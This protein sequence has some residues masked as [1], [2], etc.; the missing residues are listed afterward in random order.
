[1]NKRNGYLWA[2]IV[3]FSFIYGFWSLTKHNRFQTDAVDL[4]IFDQP[5][6]HYSRFETP[7]STVKYNQYPGE[8]ILGDHFHPTIALLSPLYWVWDDVRIILIAQAVLVALSVWPIYQVA[9]KLFNS[10]FF[11]LCLSFSYLTFIGL[12]TALDYDFHEITIALLPF[13]F[14]IYFLLRGKNLLY[15]LS[16]ALAAF[17]K[18][19]MTLFVAMLGLFSIF[20]FKK[21]KLGLVTFV[22][23]MSLYFIVTQVFIPFFKHDRFAYEELD[24]RLGKTTLDLIQT[25]FTNPV[26]VISTIF[27][28]VLKAKTILNLLASFAFLPLL[29]PTA[30]LMT[31]PNLAS[32]FLTRLSQ[33]WLIRFQYNAVLSPILA[34]AVVFGL[35]RLKKISFI[36]KRFGQILPVF[37]VLLVVAPLLQTVRTNSPLLRIFN[38]ASYKYEERFLVNYQLLSRIPKDGGVSV[39]AQSSFVP[40]LSHRQQIYRFEDDLADKRKPDYVLMSAD[41]ASDPPYV[42]KDLEN[43]I[44]ILRKNPAYEVLYWDGVRLL[45]KLKEVEL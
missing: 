27:L 37:S 31:L 8:H 24:P 33:R 17:T 40:H 21:Y 29:S 28:P 36:D 15:F 44:E 38:P 20:E 25:A 10:R 5:L 4:A 16:I 32:R 2:L 30:L 34:V 18:E 45:M 42:R 14:A 9:Q 19:D 12:Q 41:E 26:L 6:W 35:A 1:M 7:L 22:F 13:S 43:K 11:S 23:G 3:V 39:M